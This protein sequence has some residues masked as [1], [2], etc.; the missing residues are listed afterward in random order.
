MYSDKIDLFL[1]YPRPS[2]YTTLPVPHHRNGLVFFLQETLYSARTG[3]PAFAVTGAARRRRRS[4]RRGRRPPAPRQ[5]QC[6]TTTCAPPP[7]K[8]G[9]NPR[10][11]YGPVVWCPSCRRQTHALSAVLLCIVAS[12]QPGRSAEGSGQVVGGGSISDMKRLL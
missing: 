5:A 10:S 9:C 4:T 11:H 8:K 1:Q 12:Q 2:S 3:R 6:F 7:R